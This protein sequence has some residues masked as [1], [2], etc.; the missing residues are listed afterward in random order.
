[1]VQVRVGLVIFLV[2]VVLLLLLEPLDEFVAFAAKRLLLGG[3][4]SV[5]VVHPL[6]DPLK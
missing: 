4:V 5:D 6:Q 1:M 2:V 3:A